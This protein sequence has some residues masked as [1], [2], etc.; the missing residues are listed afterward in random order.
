MEIHNFENLV[1]LH[2]DVI[3]F[4]FEASL[5]KFSHCKIELVARN[6]LFRL[7]NRDTIEN[8]YLS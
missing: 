7:C 6:D 8:I 3:D 1:N 4:F 5:K 2:I